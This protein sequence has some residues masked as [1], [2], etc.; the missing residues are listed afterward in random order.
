MTENLVGLKSMVVE[1]TRVKWLNYFG[2][3]FFLN[4]FSPYIQFS[5]CCPIVVVTTVFLL[6]WTLLWHMPQFEVM[7]AQKP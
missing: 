4:E 6:S 5:N 7:R 1:T 3:L 2:M